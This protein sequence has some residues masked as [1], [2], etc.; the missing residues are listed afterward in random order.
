VRDI[1]LTG[2]GGGCEGVEWGVVFFIKSLT[3]QCFISCRFG[4]PEDIIVI[5]GYCLSSLVALYKW[6]FL[7]AFFN[8]I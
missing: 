4:V 3:R 6:L 5:A 8:I 2:G 7:L 1:H